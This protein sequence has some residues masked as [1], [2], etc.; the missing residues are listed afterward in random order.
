MLSLK[1]RKK[2]LGPSFYSVCWMTSDMWMRMDG[3]LSQIDRRQETI[4]VH[5]NYLFIFKKYH[6]LLLEYELLMYICVF[7]MVGI[8]RDL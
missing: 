7:F 2:S 1:L 3:S 4:N 5:V 8:S 6:D